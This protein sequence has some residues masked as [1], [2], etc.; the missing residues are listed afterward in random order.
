VRTPGGR[1]PTGPASF[2][3]SGA[4]PALRT[5]G[6]V[7][8]A[9]EEVD[10]P[11]SPPERFGAVL[12]KEQYRR[13]HEA[14]LEARRR[15][16]GITI[17][18]V[19]S[20]AYGGGVAEMLRS[21]LAYI[22]GAGLEA[23]WAVVP[24]SPEFFRVTKRIHNHLHG[25][26]GDGGALDDDA[27][28]TYEDEL[29]ESADDLARRVRPGDCV[30]LH[31]PQT[32]GLVGPMRR[33]G[34]HVVWRCHVGLDMPNDLARRA[35]AFLF[36]YVRESEAF[37]FSRAAFVW[38]VL[39]PVHVA[40]IPPS[41]DAFSTKN[42]E[43]DPDAVRAILAAAGVVPD[44][45]AGP[46]LFVRHDGSQAPVVSRASMIELA[47]IPTGARLVTQV[48]RWD[49]LKD[50][51]GVIAGFAQHVAPRVDAHL[52][53]AGPDVRAV[54]DD[55]EGAQVLDD[56]TRAWE[57]LPAEVRGRVHLACLPMA[58]SEENAGIVNALQ[59]RSDVV[60]QKSLAEGFG[61]TVA[62]AMWKG[63]PVVA[64]RIGGIQDQIEH[65]R[66]GLLLDDARDLPA[67]GDLV[68]SLLQG[69]ERAA[70]MGRAAQ[71]R[72]RD[73]FLGPHNLMRYARLLSD[74]L[75]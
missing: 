18:N 40:V 61:L 68:V 31:D 15:F 59:R 74:L 73:H 48:S 52:V 53:V 43:L 12:T 42:V 35:W 44:P 38:D 32:A 41:L 3:L 46:A 63:R 47:P 11:S 58:D 36:P 39:D 65:G 67:F 66:T 27:R 49:G 29:R 71:A 8:C 60:V 9:I 33:A 51:A 28:R 54:T 57:R 19:N 2:L 55:P 72:V 4:D 26:P 7:K 24:A 45:S 30:I 13:F 14:I 5:L 70:A 10:V 6:R 64:S 50:P 21:L 1:P 34:A 62:E 69:P 22:C 23:R 17:F 75:G 25:A 56:C 16:Q 37:V 20:T